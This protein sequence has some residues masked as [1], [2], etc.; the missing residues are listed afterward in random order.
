MKDELLKGQRYDVILAD[1]P[2]EY[3]DKALAGK[4]GAG[5]KY[6]LMS[7]EQLEGLPVGQL[8]APDCALLVWATMPKLRNALA[9]I[10]RWGFEYRTVAF[11]W[12]KLNASG[13]G[14]FTGM[15]HWTRANA[16]LCLLGIRGAP[17]RCDA[18][19]SQIV[20]ARIRQHSRKPDE[21]YTKIERLFGDVRRIEL[22]ARH[23]REG[24]DGSGNEIPE[25]K[26]RVL[27]AVC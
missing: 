11:T 16:E 21:V 19:V 27:G 9:L 24:W 22:F 7:D 13:I 23:R 26:Q 10:H 2:W 3:D 1:P 5:C 8:A 6:D 12:V 18:G 14:Y 20:A 15:G 25:E 17:A 4:R